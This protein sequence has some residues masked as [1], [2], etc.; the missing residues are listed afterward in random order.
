MPIGP[1][2]MIFENNAVY[3]GPVYDF[4]PHGIGVM[5]YQ[6]GQIYEG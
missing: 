5:K 2:K 3:S 1:V 6:G 4:L